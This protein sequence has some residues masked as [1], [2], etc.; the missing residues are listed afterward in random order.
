MLNKIIETLLCFS[1]AI[2]EM[3]AF[4][5]AKNIS[6]LFSNAVRSSTVR[7]LIDKKIKKRCVPLAVLS[8]RCVQ[9]INLGHLNKV[10]MTVLD[11][12]VNRSV[13]NSIT[14]VFFESKLMQVVNIAKYSCSCFSNQVKV[15]AQN[16]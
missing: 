1:K 9:I 11:K 14:L 10:P 8:N 7:I 2:I 5:N 15:L 12:F 16:T 6:V 13:P 3:M 4:S